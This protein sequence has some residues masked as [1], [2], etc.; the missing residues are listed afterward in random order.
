MDTILGF[1]VLN[2][3]KP[4][5]D[6]LRIFLEYSLAVFCSVEGHFELI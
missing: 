3:L 5:V 1:R 2:K 4:R 6:Y